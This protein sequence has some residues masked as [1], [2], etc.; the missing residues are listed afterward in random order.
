MKIL[1]II[2]LLCSSLDSI[3]TETPFKDCGSELGTIQSFEVTNCTTPPC[4]F[5]KGR[6]YAM[7]LTFQAK[8]P[9]KSATV[10]A[11]GK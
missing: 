6:T 8:A 7:N 11:F 3:W 9:S 2:A 1:F 5:I 4:V 10:K